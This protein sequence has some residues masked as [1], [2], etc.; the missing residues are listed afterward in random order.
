MTYQWSRNGGPITGATGQVLTIASARFA[1]LGAYRVTASDANGAVTTAPVNLSVAP[2][3]VAHPQNQ[4][5]RLGGTATFGVTADGAGPLSYVWLRGRR[6]LPGQT[7]ATLMITNGCSRQSDTL[8]SIASRPTARS[9]IGCSTTC[10]CV[11]PK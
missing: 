3:I 2:H 6:P 5:A 7:N 1:D 11:R 9:A 8:I 10:G 4:F